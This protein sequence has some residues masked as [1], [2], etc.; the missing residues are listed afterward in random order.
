MATV[1]LRMLQG[2]TRTRLSAA[3]AVAVGLVTAACSET[4]EES[5][6]TGGG[7]GGDVSDLSPQEFYEK[8]IHPELV[9]TC[10]TCHKSTANCTPVFMADDPGVAYDALKAYE[11]LVTHPDNSNL[12]FHGT[13][14]G[15][16]LSSAQEDLVIE[17]L[18][19]EV[20]GE[21]TGQTMRTALVTF[22]DCMEYDD[23]LA[24]GVDL[25]AF[26]PVTEF[27]QCGGCHG[28]GEA[29]TWIGY[30]KPEMWEKNAQLP[31]IKRLVKP[32]YDGKNFVDLAFSDRWAQKVE[33]ANFCESSHPGAQVPAAIEASIQNYVDITHARWTADACSP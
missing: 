16:A 2:K 8:F 3:V 21:P 19:L 27:G 9:L 22:G 5:Q 12:I 28:T 4:P 13:H 24:E 26:D 30:N 25:I 15:P 32:V 6:G 33:E 17:W 14:S 10:A 18:T 1:M 31:W 7:G 20:P 23:F 29:G 11:G